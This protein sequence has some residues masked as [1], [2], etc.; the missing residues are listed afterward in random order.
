MKVTFEDPYLNHMQSVILSEKCCPVSVQKGYLKFS[1]IPKCDATK[2]VS[3]ALNV[4]DNAV[5]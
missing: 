1:S 2:N 3:A 5:N 4:I